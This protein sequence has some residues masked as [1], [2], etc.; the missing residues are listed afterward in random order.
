MFNLYALCP[1]QSGLQDKLIKQ[2]QRVY[3]IIF[4][5]EIFFSYKSLKKINYV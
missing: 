5:I 2:Y 4:D 3:I 1:L